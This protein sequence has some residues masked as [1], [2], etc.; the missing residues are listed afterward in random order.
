VADSGTLKFRMAQSSS[1]VGSTVSY[2]TSLSV[3]EAAYAD[4]RSALFIASRRSE[5]EEPARGGGAVPNGPETQETPPCGYCIWRCP[6]APAQVR[7]RNQSRRAG[8]SRHCPAGRGDG[9]ARRRGHGSTPRRGTSWRPARAAAGT[10]STCAAT[11][12]RANRRAKRVSGESPTHDPVSPWFDLRHVRGTLL[13]SIGQPHAPYGRL[14]ELLGRVPMLRASR[15]EDRKR[16][17]QYSSP[18]LSRGSAGADVRE[19]S[20]KC[21]RG[22]GQAPGGCSAPG[23]AVVFWAA[24]L[25]REIRHADISVSRSATRPTA[26][27]GGKGREPSGTRAF[28]ETKDY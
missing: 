17:P 4:L 18:H 21:Q 25:G 6:H 24:S 1:V 26:W 11:G 13:G 16:V 8:S 14:S 5:S 7:N 9:S 19:S 20:G 27:V 12:N 23:P 3:A 15:R 2:F 28:Y 10:T 22:A